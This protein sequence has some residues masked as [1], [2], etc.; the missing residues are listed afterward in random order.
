M[1]QYRTSMIRPIHLPRSNL[2]SAD[3]ELPDLSSTVDRIVVSAIS[4]WLPARR[5]GTPRLLRRTFL[6]TPNME[7]CIL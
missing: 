6:L 3:L 7:Q 1:P 4:G 5:G 2:A